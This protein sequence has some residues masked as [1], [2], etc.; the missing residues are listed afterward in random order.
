M[1]RIL[2]PLFFCM[3]FFFSQAQEKLKN[4]DDA[5][6][7]I[8]V[9]LSAQKD[10]ENIPSITAMV[11]KNQE[12]LWKG[13]F[14]SI[15]LSQNIPA[16]TTTNCSICSITKS[17]TAV[18]IMKLVD[19]EKLSLDDKVKD[20]LPFYKVKLNTI[21]NNEATIRSLL[22]HSSGLPSNTIHS[23]FT[24]PNF[25]FP[26]QS[27]FRE[28]LKNMEIK[29]NVGSNVNYSN[30]GYALLG[31]IIEKISGV[32]YETFLMNE[33]IIP[34]QMNNTYF[35]MKPRNKQQAIGYT[36]INRDL[37]RNQVN[38]FNTKSMKPSMGLWT[39]MDD[40]AKYISWQ[41]RLREITTTEILKPS[42]LK[43][44]HTTQATN[45]YMSWGLGFETIKGS[46]GDDWI[47]HGGTCPG[48]VS[49]MQLNLTTK[50]G[51]AVM[52]NAN[53]A[54]T[55]KY[56]N[57]IKQILS[58]AKILEENSNG[59]AANL[60][61]Y[62][63]FYNMNPWN[64]LTYVSKWGND[65]VM[66]QLPENSPKY[67]MQ[68]LRHMSDDTFRFIKK[69]GT[70]GEEIVFKRNKKGKVEKF[71]EGGNFKSKVIE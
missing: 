28:A 37:T 18:A 45:K 30:V 54:R 6:K 16:K 23:Y 65:L 60:N 2:L 59:K 42:S 19:E 48:F 66:L 57:G 47:S 62:T 63:G 3:C 31:E 38:L 61:E 12:V 15:D 11:V 4:Y 49:L 68:F 1:N 34:L 8:E 56:I 14:G 40:L 25:T 20:I 24:G 55:F 29:S 58:K 21:N 27:E 33:V 5:F 7:L 67:G 35:E 41:F 52:I 17:F 71:Y 10:F 43:S 51:F 44:M 53:R 64:S 26:T 46:N 9:W 36:A 22:S 70:L 69:D 50:M 13:A 39:S 32:S